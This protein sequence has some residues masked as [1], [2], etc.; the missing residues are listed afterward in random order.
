MDQEVQRKIV[1]RRL[2]RKGVGLPYYDDRQ[3]KRDPYEQVRE[4]I[5]FWTEG[6]LSFEQLEHWAIDTMYRF[7]DDYIEKHTMPDDGKK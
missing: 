4:M 2:A 3:P 6:R 1:A 7:A 5:V